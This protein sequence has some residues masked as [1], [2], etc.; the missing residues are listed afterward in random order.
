MRGLAV[1]EEV[2]GGDGV[3]IFYPANNQEVTRWLSYDTSTV[4]RPL[5]C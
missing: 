4:H 1:L 2:A 5:R 3:F